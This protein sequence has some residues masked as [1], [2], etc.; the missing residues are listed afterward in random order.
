MYSPI[1]LFIFM[2]YLLPFTARSL[3]VKLNHVVV[4]YLKMIIA[5][6][7]TTKSKIK[8]LPITTATTNEKR[9]YQQQ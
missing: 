5:P 6:H 8:L 4:S 9:R 3:V 2:F 7:S 1:F